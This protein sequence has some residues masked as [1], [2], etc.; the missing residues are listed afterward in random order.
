MILDVTSD[1]FLPTVD[2][3][4]LEGGGQVVP[5]VLCS[6]FLTNIISNTCALTRCYAS[7]LLWERCKRDRYG[8]L[9]FVEVAI[10]QVLA[11]ST[12]LVPLSWQRSVLVRGVVA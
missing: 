11:T 10:G 2:G 12:P 3:T 7:A 6:G 4:V 5:L 8:W 1:D 9:P